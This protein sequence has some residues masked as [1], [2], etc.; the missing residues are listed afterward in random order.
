MKFVKSISRIG[1][2]TACLCLLFVTTAFATSSRVT[3]SS[4]YMAHD[5]TFEDNHPGNKMYSGGLDIVYAEFAKLN[6]PGNTNN[7]DL[8]SR[9]II[10]TST[11]NDTGSNHLE[12]GVHSYT[13]GLA[14]V[15]FDM[16]DVAFPQ[17]CKVIGGNKIWFSYTGSAGAGYY[18][19]PWD[20][21]NLVPYTGAPTLEIDDIACNWEV[22]ERN[23][24]KV[25]YCGLAGS[26]WDPPP[27]DPHTVYYVDQSGASPSLVKILEIGG[28]SSGFAFD[29]D[30]NLWSGEYL[31][32]WTPSM[33]VE[34]CR[35]GMWTKDQVDAVIAGG[36]SLTWADAD[37][38]LNLG[39]RSADPSL[40]WGPNDIEGDPDGNIY[41]SVNTYSSW[42]NENEF[43]AVRKLH[44]VYNEATDEWSIVHD[45]YI[46]DDDCGINNLWD[47]HKTLS[48]DGESNIDAGGYTNP[49]LLPNVT[50]NRL[51]MDMDHDQGYPN[52]PDQFVVFAAD[53]DADGD[54]VPDSVDNAPEAANGGLIGASNQQDTDWDLYGNMCDADLNNS[55]IVNNSDYSLFSGAWNGTDPE[56]DFNSSGLVNQVDYSIF[57]TRYDTTAPWY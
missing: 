41:L 32:G 45:G 56:A 44:A 12:I 23:D 47:W 52:K 8:L 9:G 13:G 2:A 54:G 19:I 36:T 46:S 57:S 27:P 20:P 15:L 7:E 26:S 5:Y 40:N 38:I 43:G 22:E 10:H 51:F 4:G 53:F 25:F 48:Y 39:T 35:L 28:Y 6:D 18:S 29:K 37:A 33:H 50:G 16:P 34:P 3:P 14:T 30:G 55:G 17:D 1:L 31:L 11:Y 24:G 21:D 42:S 49:E